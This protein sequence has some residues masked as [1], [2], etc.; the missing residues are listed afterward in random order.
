VNGVEWQ[1]EASE[2]VNGVAGDTAV[3]V[4][5]AGWVAEGEANAGAARV[6]VMEEKA[7]G[8]GAAAVNLKPGAA[9]EKLNVRV[10]F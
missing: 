3:E 10:V 8:G 5:P 4:E 9:V 7:G 1:A 6:E 2:I